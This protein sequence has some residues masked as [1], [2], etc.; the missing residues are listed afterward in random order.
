MGPRDLSSLRAGIIAAVAAPFLGWATPLSAQSTYAPYQFTTLAGNPSI[1]GGGLDGAGPAA[2]FSGPGGLAVDGAGN[3]YVADT[4]NG[5][6][7]KV[8]PSGVVTTLAGTL[9]VVGDADGIGAGAQ[10]KYPAGIAVGGDGNVYVADTENSEIRAITPGGVVTTLAG[11]PGVGGSANGTGGAARFDAPFGIAVDGAGNLYVADTDNDVIR[12]ISPGAVVTTLAGTAGTAF[13]PSAADGTGGAARFDGPRGVA[14]DS[15]G[16]VYVADTGND[17][18]RKITPDGVVT[19][20]AG[21]AGNAGSADGTG[22][23]ARFDTP[24]GVAVD[25]LGNVYVA[26]SGNL[27]IRMITPGGAVTTLAGFSGS[28]PAHTDGTGP[29]ARFKNPVGVAAGPGGLVY[30]AD[31]LGNTVSDGGPAPQGPASVTLGNLYQ[32][33]DGTPKTAT[34][35]TNPAGLAT[36]V[37]YTSSGALAT[38]DGAAP[39]AEGTYGVF[40]TVTGPGPSGY[41]TGILTIGPGQAAQPSFVVRTTQAGGSFLWG[42]AAGPPGLVAVGVGGTILSSSDGSTW[43]PRNSGTANWLVG[44][45]YGMG[46]YV[47]VGDHGSVLLSADGVTWLSVAQSATTAR[48]N[49]VACAAGQYVA[50][51]EGGAII[52]SPDGRAWTARS[53]GATG[54]LRGLAYAGEINESANILPRI[55]PARFITA[56]EGGSL[57]SS[58]DGITWVNEGILN[59]LAPVSAGQNLEAIISTT[60]TNV[61]AVGDGGTLAADAVLI[62]DN[63]PYEGLDVHAYFMPVAFRGLVQGSNALFAAGENGTILTAPGVNAPW[64]QVPSG[65][66]ANL[67][68]GAAVGDSIF[69]VGDNRTIVQSTR[70][71]DSRLVNLSCRTQVGTGGGILIAG[72][73]VGGAGTSGSAPLLVRGSG[74]ALVPFDVLGT[75][76]DPELQL[77]GTGAGSSLVAVNTGWAGD[78]VVSAEAAALGAFAWSDPSSHDAAVFETLPT[79]PYTANISGESGDTGI[80]LAEIYDG[81]PAGT[82]TPASPRLT[83]LSARAE[84]GAG[85]NALIAGF[86]IGGTVPKT[87]LVRASGPALKAFGVSGTLADPALQIFG[88]GTGN[89]AL[90]ANTGWAGD[91]GIATAASWVGAFSWGLAATS[92]SAILV[93]LPPGP[94]TANVSGASGDSGVALVEVYEVQ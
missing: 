94:Y 84:V 60:D 11:S 77:F 12:K 40:A 61:V 86:V 23:A 48:L 39:T 69:F 26:D 72:F 21:A 38:Y 55:F 57:L 24:T 75:L 25:A 51:G 8:T 50:V 85:A 52:T 87:V 91:P 5:A 29:A 83:N 82:A 45:T 15:G 34:V 62:P 1:A 66:S 2:L 92:D 30:V 10:F 17:L 88:T 19:T 35:A 59:G 7:R 20:L 3:V 28:F 33:Y 68:A 76:A 41:A 32:G 73:V 71:V 74:P 4:S 90:A 44:V 47:A 64:L 54:W 46:Q 78:P 13:P 56:G 93:T 42:I 65:T 18:I 67:V 37:T 6:I 70:P 14:V 81:T 80:A 43:T 49:N 58:T 79:G 27:R 9:G 53:S 89:A 22:T 16:N 31:S 36:E 63:S